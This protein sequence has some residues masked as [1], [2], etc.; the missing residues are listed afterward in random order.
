MN[1]L[2]IGDSWGTLSPWTRYNTESRNIINIAVMGQSN[3]NGLVSAHSFLMAN[4]IKFDLIVWYFTSLLRD[5]IKT[6]PLFNFNDYLN[7]L[8]E[9]T[10]TYV[11]TI[12]KKHPNL[13]W[14]IIGGHAPIYDKKRYAW[15][16]FLVEN[17]R[18]ELLQEVGETAPI[19]QSLGWHGK[20]ERI[21]QDS[22]QCNDDIIKEI[23]AEDIIR[24]LSKK[25]TPDIF[26]DD[27]HPNVDKCTDMCDRILK[28]FKQ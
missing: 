2:V 6:E 14:A 17:W 28:Y 1:I 24:K 18:E 26:C 27:I 5:P 4:D 21:K 8:N 15:A 22:P 23:E 7:L 19:N 10:L 12:R 9:E 20:L 16:D 3:I 13:K 25:Y 11:E